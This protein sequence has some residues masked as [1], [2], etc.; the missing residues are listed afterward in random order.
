MAGVGFEPTSLGYEPSKETTPPTRYSHLSQIWTDVCSL[1]TSHPSARRLGDLFFYFLLLY[2]YYNKNFFDFQIL[3]S[4]TK[5]IRTP[6]TGMKTQRPEPLDDGAK[7][8]LLDN[9]KICIKHEYRFFYG[10]AVYYSLPTRTELLYRLTSFYSTL[11]K[12]I[13]H[14]KRVELLR[15]AAPDSKSDVSTNST[16]SAYL[17]VYPSIGCHPLHLYFSLEDRCSPTSI[18]FYLFYSTK[19]EPPSFSFFG[20]TTKYFLFVITTSCWW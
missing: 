11:Y 14:L 6:V 13:V 16:I 17:A 15:L 19:L 8:Q 1:R 12:S 20:F 3:K 7:L 18:R 9:V 2:K 10:A 4:D 5:E